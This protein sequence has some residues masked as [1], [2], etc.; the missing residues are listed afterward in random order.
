MSPMRVT[1]ATAG[2]LIT[3]ALTGCSGAASGDAEQDPPPTASSVSAPEPSTGTEAASKTP[4]EGVWSLEQTK[5]D[6]VRHL[7]R[8][9]FGDLVRRFIRVESVW[10]EDNWE[11]T[12]TGDRFVATWQNPD[13][14]MKVADSGTFDVQGDRVVLSFLADEV[15]DT[16]TFRW[17]KEGK[18]L[19]LV[20][21]RRD[22]AL[23]KG[24]PD[25]AYWRAYLTKPLTR[26]S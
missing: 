3:L 14:S 10:R 25:E 16:T 13:G 18:R 7:R 26:V 9:G 21:E 12:F 8:A 24:I 2:L 11:W 6:V 19:W 4:L 17:R 20:W 23:Y 1:A 5:A 22:G 15:G